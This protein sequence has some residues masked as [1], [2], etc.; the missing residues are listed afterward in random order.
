MASP[1]GIDDNTRIVSGPRGDYCAV[2]SQIS[3]V[4]GVWNGHGWW[5]FSFHWSNAGITQ[6]AAQ[7]GPF[8]LP[9]LSFLPGYT[10][11]TDNEWMQITSWTPN[12]TMAL[13]QDGTSNQVVFGEKFIPAWGLEQGS[14]PGFT[15]DIS[16]TGAMWDWWN[17]GFARALIDV[18]AIDPGYQ[19]IARSPNEP[20][21]ERDSHINPAG[22][23][24]NTSF[25][26]GSNHP[27][28]VNFALGDGA[29]R[30]VSVTINKQT[31]VALAN[32]NDG[33]PVTLP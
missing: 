32:V 16:F 6:P 11:S 27:G 29:V 24:S 3:T 2:V 21:L 23:F 10:G 7:R 31:I 18:S 30:G 13:W 14:L 8:R 33:V 28:T 1:D 26:Y 22:S 12:Q 19:P 25:G 15:W 4:P 5:Y 9:A 20:S 17:S